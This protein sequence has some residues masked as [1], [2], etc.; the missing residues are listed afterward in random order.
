VLTKP[1]V[2]PDVIL[3]VVSIGADGHSALGRPNPEGVLHGVSVYSQDA[4]RC[5]ASTD[6]SQQS[7]V[8]CRKSA[9][10]HVSIAKHDAQQVSAL[11]ALSFARSSTILALSGVVTKQ[12]AAAKI[13]FAGAI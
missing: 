7:P 9:P 2:S 13:A 4:C 5:M 12:A 11:H 8:P 10:T 1:G 6:L 3:V